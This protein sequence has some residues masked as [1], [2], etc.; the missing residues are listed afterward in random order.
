MEAAEHAGVQLVRELGHRVGREGPAEVLFALGKLGTVSVDRAAR[1]IDEPGHAGVA[2]GVEKSQRP[3][4]VG[5]VRFERVLDRAW[6]G[7]ERRLVQ[8][9]IHPGHRIRTDLERGHVSLDEPEAR[10]A[11]RT[12]EAANLVEIGLLPRSPGCPGP[13]PPD[14]GPRRLSSRFEPMNPATPVIS[15]RRGLSL[16]WSPTCANDG[17]GSV[18]SSGREKAN[19]NLGFDP[20]APFV[21][22]GEVGAAPTLHECRRRSPPGEPRESPEQSK[23][24]RLASPGSRRG[25]RSIPR[26]GGSANWR[27]DFGQAGLQ[28]ESPGRSSRFGYP[29]L[30]RVVALSGP[31]GP[32][33]CRCDGTW[34]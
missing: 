5:G 21:A 13:R 16:N 26:I 23:W 25:R 14:R 10:P 30:H 31:H 4:D 12:D 32:I 11:V 15:Q 27:H 7:A 9:D 22:G 18:L 29:S 20:N 28:N 2:R 17:H 6:H 19:R 8:D 24:S 1:G 33:G 3:R 34:R